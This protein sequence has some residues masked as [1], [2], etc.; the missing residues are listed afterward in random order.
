MVAGPTL[1]GGMR[2]RGRGRFPTLRV[3]AVDSVPVAFAGSDGG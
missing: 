3:P 1:S 2:G